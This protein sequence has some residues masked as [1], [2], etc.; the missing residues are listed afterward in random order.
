MKKRG[1][2]AIGLFV[3]AAFGA[4]AAYAA[5]RP[6]PYAGNVG[7]SY[8]L[9]FDSLGWLVV[10]APFA[11]FLAAG[12]SR[13]QD[14]RVEG[15]RV[16]RHDGP[17]IL[18]HW[19]H[20]LG[21]AVLLVTGIMLGFLIVPRSV[22]GLAAAGFL[23]NLHFVAVV[24]FLFGTIYWLANTLLATKRFAEHLPTD[25]AIP[26]TV[27]HY[28]LLLGFKKFEMPPEDKYFESE[29]MAFILALLATGLI[30]LSGFVKV[31]AHF[32]G[33]H[34]AVL[35]VANFTHDIATVL[36][37]AFF[38]A[39]VFFAAIAPF[40]WP[41]LGSMFTGYVTLEHARHEHAG[42]LARLNG[43]DAET[44]ATAPEREPAVAARTAE[45]VPSADPAL[46]GS[47]SN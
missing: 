13:R 27:Q 40:S 4:Y 33:I 16:L 3:L 46:A 11:G 34:G 29:R 21:T 6:Q 41:V 43:S 37:L 20:G 15:D 36:M 39:H 47:P 25:K 7:T 35:G 9:L 24:F 5:S 2:I 22:G 12:L 23:Y 44:P 18:E 42:W 28:G 31:A 19:A 32:F 45:P 30:I 17:A 38:L 1:V 8:V 14:P 10:A 26:Y